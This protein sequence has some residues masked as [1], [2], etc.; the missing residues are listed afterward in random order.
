MVLAENLIIGL[1]DD[2]L[3]P[4]PSLLVWTSLHGGQLLVKVGLRGLLLVRTERYCLMFAALVGA[5]L[6]FNTSM[7]RRH[8]LLRAEWHACT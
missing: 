1:E 8:F 7:S 5:R 4:R 3:V 6:S 2:A